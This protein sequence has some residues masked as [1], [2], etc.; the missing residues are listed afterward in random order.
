M[1]GNVTLNWSGPGPRRDTRFRERNRAQFTLHVRYIAN[2][3]HRP[4]NGLGR[5]SNHLGGNALARLQKWKRA[6]DAGSGGFGGLISA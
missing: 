2:G 5:L 4:R 1:G 3:T 6:I